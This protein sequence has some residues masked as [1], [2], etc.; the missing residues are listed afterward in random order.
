LKVE[1]YC[2]NCPEFEPDVNKD[3]HELVEFDMA[4]MGERRKVFCDTRV[5]CVHC[6]RCA[7]VYQKAVEFVNRKNDTA[8]DPNGIY[9]NSNACGV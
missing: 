9:H 2:H 1:E 4:G 8:S 6:H 7:A 5:T 3:E